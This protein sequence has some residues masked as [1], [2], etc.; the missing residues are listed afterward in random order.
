L[1]PWAANAKMLKEYGG[2]GIAAVVP[3]ELADRRRRMKRGERKSKPIGKA[4]TELDRCTSSTLPSPGAT[5]GN[6][7]IEQRKKMHN[8]SIYSGIEEW[9]TKD[10]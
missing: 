2:D 9:T 8:R 4:S 5:S 6:N 7:H 1:Q 3:A 10:I